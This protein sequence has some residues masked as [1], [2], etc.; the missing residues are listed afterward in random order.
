MNAP[1]S[2]IQDRL[3]H[4]EP[5]RALLHGRVILITGASRGIGRA[6]SRAAAG[7]GAQ[8]VLLARSVAALEDLAD[9]IAAHGDPEPG[10]LPVDLEGA[11]IDDY[12]EIARLLRERYGR[13]DNLVLNA[14]VLG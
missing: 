10:I 9:E 5:P 6:I 13:L 1:D 14:G 8:T 12:R 2:A 4:Y 7:A 3:W 11:A